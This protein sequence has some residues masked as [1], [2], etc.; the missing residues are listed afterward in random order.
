MSAATMKDSP[1]TPD[2]L[3]RFLG[4]S[5][6][7]PKNSAA[8]GFYMLRIVFST[9]TVH[10]GIIFA[11]IITYQALKVTHCLK[12]ISE[13]GSCGGSTDDY[14]DEKECTR[15]WGLIKPD[16]L[17]PVLGTAA[18]IVMAISASLVGTA[19]DFTNHRRQLSL[20]GNMMC[21]L[22][23]LLCVSI[24]NPTETTLLVSTVGLFV[25]LIFKD[26]NIMANE[27]YAPELSED[28][29]EVATAVTT[30]YFW[31][32]TNNVALIIFWVI[33]SL[34]VPQS[35]F[36]GVVSVGTALLVA[37]NTAICYRRLPDVPAARVLPPNSN[38]AKHTFV[39]LRDLACECYSDY[40]DLGITLLAGMVFDPAL[41]SIFAAAIL[42]LISKYR[43][44]AE[45]STMIIGVGI[46]GAIPAG[47]CARWVA[48]TPLLDRF[49]TFRTGRPFDQPVTP[50]S[51][52]G[53][54]SV[55][56]AIELQGSAGPGPECAM[57]PVQMQA[58]PQR[59]LNCLRTGLVGVIVITVLV[60]TTL[61]PCNMGL[62]M[63]FCACWGFSL[64]FCWSFYQ[65]LRTAIVPGG[66]EAE[67]AGLNLSMF[68]ALIWLPLLVFSI[69]NEVWSITGAILL[70][71]VFFVV[72]IAI[73]SC[74]DVNKAMA[75]QAQTLNQR[76]WAGGKSANG[77]ALNG[78]VFADGDV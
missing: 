39:R 11:G 61:T 31:L 23:L 71:N 46:V 51:D 40:P 25:I 33:I 1:W 52:D 76:R 64:V 73:L 8:T 57:D 77:S 65:M 3:D 44:T 21:V 72:G 42:V 66:R 35:A 36:G 69:A 2:F 20:V 55:E 53:E 63:V 28:P 15:L 58:H 24:V 60:P 54:E 22:G 62:A 59:M 6:D 32:T 37:I 50:T 27:A 12:D 19:M 78:K 10:S 30:G 70:L 56:K 48:T 7:S 49:E 34:I 5:K 4:W 47:L 74:V 13:S 17:F 75:A 38:I 9:I 18:A 16:S 43:F 26:F 14:D 45:Q 29:V 41:V 68:S 67:F